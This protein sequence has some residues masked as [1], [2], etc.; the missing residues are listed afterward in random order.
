MKEADARVAWWSAPRCSAEE[1]VHRQRLAS[2][3]H[4]RHDSLDHF[5]LMGDHHD[6]EYRQRMLALSLLRCDCEGSVSYEMCS[7]NHGTVTTIIELAIHEKKG[8]E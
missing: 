4:V 3:S 1:L 7:H 6:L 5:I 2:H 8:Q